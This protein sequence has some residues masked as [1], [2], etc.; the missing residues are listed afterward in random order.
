MLHRNLFTVLIDRYR[1]VVDQVVL[2]NIEAI[3]SKED[4]EEI[5]ESWHRNF[6]SVID[7]FRLVLTNGILVCHCSQL[8]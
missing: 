7:T 2:E 6:K 3:Q 1:F 8:K 4:D 5:G